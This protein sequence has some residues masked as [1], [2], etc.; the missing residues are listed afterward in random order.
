MYSIQWVSTVPS[1]TPVLGV[2]LWCGWVIHRPSHI[3][4]QPPPFL[5]SLSSSAVSDKPSSN[6]SAISIF[7]SK[8]LMTSFEIA[9]EGVG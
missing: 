1:L 5:P 2:E 9:D 7:E 3:I 8:F 6:P 4:K